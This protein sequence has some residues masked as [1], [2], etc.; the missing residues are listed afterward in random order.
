[1]KICYVIGG[2]DV[3]GAERQLF[4]L[5]ETIARKVPVMIVSLSDSSTKLV[6]AFRQLPGVDVCTVR[7]V[8]RVDPT[9]LT[10]LIQVYRRERPQIV[11]TFL[12]TANYWGRVAAFLAGVPITIAGE[13]NIEKERGRVANALDTALSFYTTR[14][15]VN[16]AAIKDSLT[17]RGVPERKIQIIRNG[18]PRAGAL[19]DSDRLRIRQELGA[20]SSDT[21]VV[22]IGRLFPQKNPMLFIDMAQRVLTAGARCKF[23][24]VGDG[25]L[26][27]IIESSIASRGMT[28]SIMVTGFRQDVVRI[29]SAADVLVLTSDWEG[30]PNVILEA[31][32]SGTPSVATD[33]GGVREL[34]VDGSN[35]YV[36]PRGDAERLSA[37]VLSMFQSPEIRDHLGRCGREYVQKHFSI[38]RMVD[39]TA[40]LYNALLYEKRLPPLPGGAT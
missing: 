25:P 26:R 9:L 19:L 21:L 4:Y 2:L 11:H 14:V 10:R 18:V 30:M 5:V 8:G 37:C 27:S 40:A 6:P 39:E 20:D 28:R 15:V 3:G 7:K 17:M 38:D 33:V 36:V 12:R 32:S 16:A 35:G 1:M 22:F 29:L 24:I 34:I 13:R 31:L 23:A